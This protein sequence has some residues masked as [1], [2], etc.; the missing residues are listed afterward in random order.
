MKRNTSGE[1]GAGKHCEC[2]LR[3]ARV[4]NPEHRT[5]AEPETMGGGRRGS[6]AKLSPSLGKGP[7]FLVLL[8]CL[9]APQSYLH[10]MT[11]CVQ[12]Q[13]L[14]S[15]GLREQHFL[16]FGRGESLVLSVRNSLFHISRILTISMG[17]ETDRQNSAWCIL[18]ILIGCFSHSADQEIPRPWIPHCRMSFPENRE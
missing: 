18:T 4:V 6:E 8:M 17:Q 12:G 3:S 7:R 13:N 5:S 14:T 16:I 9:A 1:G 2:T 11:N 10:A 15:G